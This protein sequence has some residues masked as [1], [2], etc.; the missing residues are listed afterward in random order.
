[1]VRNSNGGG[2]AKK[3]GRKFQN[4]NRT[5]ELR[6][7]EDKNELYAIVDKIYGNGLNVYTNL[8]QEIWC[9]I[10]G[11]FKGR[12]KRNNYIEVGAWVLVG[13]YEW[14]N[15][16]DPKS[17]EL[18]YVYDR[19]DVEQL[20]N[21]PGVNLRLLNSK[22]NSA[23]IN[24]IDGAD[25]DNDDEQGRIVFSENIVDEAT[26]FAVDTGNTAIVNFDND[27]TINIDDL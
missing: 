22:I 8:G 3:Q 20:Q 1:M 27:E 9:R 19:N 7:S 5:E 24:N 21:L 15:E 6:K 18:L 4:K 17:C 13:L 14:G 26:M 11:K 10:P 16:N 12:N 23:S 2:G 25:E